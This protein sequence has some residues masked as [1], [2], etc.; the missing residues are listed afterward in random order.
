MDIESHGSPPV[1]TESSDWASAKNSRS[2]PSTRE[3]SV[4]SCPLGDGQRAGEDIRHRPDSGARFREGSRQHRSASVA[5]QQEHG[6]THR[7][8]GQEGGQQLQARFDGTGNPR[9]RSPASPRPRRNRTSKNTSL[10]AWFSFREPAGSPANIPR[11]RF[12]PGKVTTA[13]SSFSGGRE[14][15]QELRRALR[16]SAEEGRGSRAE[17]VGGSW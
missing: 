13:R 16:G 9:A 15:V 11:H 8:Q 3:G 5:T 10:T 4:E 12:C 14:D 1:T 7:V 2:E 17:Q 6:S